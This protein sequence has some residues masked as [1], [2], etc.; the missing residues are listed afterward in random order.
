MLVHHEPV[1]ELLPVGRPSSFMLVELLC[2]QREQRA[3]ALCNLLVQVG[4]SQQPPV[5]DAAALHQWKTLLHMSA[6]ELEDL[7]GCCLK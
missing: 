6:D 1:G 5:V 4:V 7:L 3:V 2:A